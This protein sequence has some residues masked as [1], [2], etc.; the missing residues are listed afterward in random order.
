VLSSDEHVMFFHS[1]RPGGCGTGG[2]WMT[3]R[4]TGV[5]RIGIRQ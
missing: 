3:R 2:I 5:R 1:T 4:T